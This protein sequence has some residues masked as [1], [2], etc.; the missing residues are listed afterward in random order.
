VAGAVR[1]VRYR[2]GEFLNAMNPVCAERNEQN[3][4]VVDCAEGYPVAFTQI[5]G[6]LARRIVFNKRVGDKLARGERVGLIKFGS[7]TDI[8]IPG[9]AEVLVQAGDRV[10]GGASVL[11]RMPGVEPEALLAAAGAEAER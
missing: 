10:R 9:Q 3:L 2:K 6:L 5:A 1:E 8:L 4:A 7:R 11:A